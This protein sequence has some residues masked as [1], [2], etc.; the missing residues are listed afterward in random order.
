M[1]LS[2]SRLALTTETDLSPGLFPNS[3]LILTTFVLS[4]LDTEPHGTKF[5]LLASVHFPS[6]PIYLIFQ[7]ILLLCYQ[8]SHCFVTHKFSKCIIFVFIEVK[9]KIV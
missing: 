1:R 5:L 3:S 4:L 7:G 6:L 2:G 9:D 8:Y